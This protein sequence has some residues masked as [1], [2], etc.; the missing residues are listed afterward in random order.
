MIKSVLMN[1]YDAKEENSVDEIFSHF[2]KRL[3]EKREEQDQSSN[4]EAIIIA[5]KK[6]RMVP[7]AKLLK[8][9]EDLNLLVEN[10][11]RYE[12]LPS[13]NPSKEPVLFR[14]YEDTSSDRWAPGK[15]IYINHPASL[16]IAVPAKNDKEGIFYISCGSNHPD[17]AIFNRYF[18]S[19]ED[20][21]QAL[22]TF[23]AKHVVNPNV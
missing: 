16:E 14:V 15:S 9:I 12:A 17:K 21:G 3:A 10:G 4:D 20:A 23:I 22:S 11:A 13:A 7:L 19:V 18:Q 6:Q 1:D 2:T 8:R 5:E